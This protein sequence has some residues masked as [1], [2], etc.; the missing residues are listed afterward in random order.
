MATVSHAPSIHRVALLVSLQQVEWWLKKWTG[1]E[2]HKQ[3]PKE[4]RNPP[5]P[6][7]HGR[8][9]GRGAH[10]RAVGPAALPAPRGERAAAAAEGDAEKDRDL[11]RELYGTA[12]AHASAVSSENN[13][14]AERAA[15]AEGQARDG[16]AMLRAAYDERVRLL[17]AEA[18]RWRAQ[19]EVLAGRDAR[20]DDEVRRRAAREPELVD[21]NER[22]RAELR[23]LEKDYR[24]MEVVVEVMT[25]QQVEESAVL[26]VIPAYKHPVWQPPSLA[27]PC[28]VSRTLESLSTMF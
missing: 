4:N 20:T 3:L 2:Y 27:H 17:E 5:T 14:L 23:V 21:E 19:C 22:L 6:H 16:L 7:G 25:K 12:S 1:E 24:R 26:D 11:F 8:A 18:A 13:A 9:S 10:P 15:V 28:S